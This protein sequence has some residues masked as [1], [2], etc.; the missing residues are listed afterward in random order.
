MEP[1]TTAEQAKPKKPQINWEDKLADQIAEAL[2]PQP[3]RQLKGIPGRQFKFDFAWETPFMV[4]VEVEGGV[5]GK[6][7]RHTSMSGFTADC[8]KYNL[9]TLQGWQVYRFTSTMV[10]DGIAIETIKQI[11]IQEAT[12]I[13]QQK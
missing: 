10:R 3:V 6:F 5:Y 2:L 1:T 7:S 13:L 4:V 9:A 12:K 8:A 11:F